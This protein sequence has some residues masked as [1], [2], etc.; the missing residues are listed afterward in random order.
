[1]SVVPDGFAD[2]VLILVPDSFS[3]VDFFCGRDI[4]AD[5]ERPV[6]SEFF[7]EAEFLP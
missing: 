7:V 3:D 4:L 6:V 5:A 1:M 2:V